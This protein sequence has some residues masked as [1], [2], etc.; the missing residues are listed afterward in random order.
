[1]ASGFWRL[2]HENPDRIALVESDGETITAGQLLRAAN[3]LVHGMRAR[4]LRRGSVVAVVMGNCAAFVEV[5]LA[6]MQAGFYFVPVGAQLAPAELAY[7]F[8]DAAIELL[9]CD[10]ATSAAVKSALSLAGASGE[11]ASEVAG[12]GAE[13]FTPYAALKEGQPGSAPP[14][15]APGERM[16]YTSGTTG[17]P[18]AVRRPLGRGDP[19]DRFGAF[20]KRHAGEIGIRPGGDTVHFVAS[21]LY[22]SAA[23]LWCADHLHLGHRVVLSKKWSAEGMLESVERQRITATFLVPTHFH[24]LLALPAATRA[25]WDLSSLRHVVHGGAPCAIEIKRKM[26]AW[27]GPVIYEAYGATEGGGSH[28]GPAEWLARPGTVGRPGRGVRILRDDGTP[29][30]PGEAGNVFFTR[31]GSTFEYHNAPEKT[32]EATRGDAFTVGDIGYLD[33]DGWLFLRDR[34]ADLIISGGV[35]IYPA[36]IEAV[37]LA[38][39]GV[40]DVAVF[41]VPDE[42]WGEQTVALVE[43][44]LSAADDLVAELLGWCRAQLASFKCPRIVKLVEALPRDPETGKLNKRSL[45]ESYLASR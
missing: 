38:H 32:A 1:M 26:L 30:E 35:N 42:E 8:R 39:E 44:A 25:R 40:R 43:P 15:R 19:D 7:V 18:K 22:H 29:C 6:A 16:L 14:E 21:P 24:R 31:T 11:L 2:A 37:L 3:E 41:G 9:V 28:V 34:K 20:A 36:E 13:A 12:S 10:G 5:Y 4:G 17:R 45:R 23:L 27:L 33:A